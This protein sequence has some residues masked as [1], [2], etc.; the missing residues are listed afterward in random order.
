MFSEWRL[1]YVSWCSTCFKP[2]LYFFLSFFCLLHSKVFL[3]WHFMS[4][5]PLKKS[6]YSNQTY[7]TLLVWFYNNDVIISILMHWLKY[8]FCKKLLRY[9]CT[10]DQL[11]TFF[12]TVCTANQSKVWKKVF[13]W[14]EV[15][16]YRS[17]F[18]QNPYFRTFAQMK[19]FDF[20]LK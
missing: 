9:K 3:N 8:G 6:L 19:N 5:N 17:N 4:W 1:K 10:S 12:L 2:M 16:L 11:N 18:L 13:N 20:K 7:S 14:S 15:H